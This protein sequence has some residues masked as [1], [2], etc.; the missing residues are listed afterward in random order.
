[1][2]F[3][4]KHVLS[5]VRYFWIF[6]FLL[7]PLKGLIAENI[8]YEFGPK[9]DNV[10]V[11]TASAGSDNQSTAATVQLQKYAQQLSVGAPD[12]HIIVAIT[13]ND[14][15][16]LPVDIPVKRYEGTQSLIQTLSAYPNAAVCLIAPARADNTRIVT[17]TSQGTTPAWLLRAVYTCLE[18]QNI[19]VDF[20]TNAVVFH[21]LGWL[22]DDPLLRLYN[23]AKIPAIKI[24][25]GADLSEVFSSVAPAVI[26]NM[27]NEWDTHYFVWKLHTKLIIINERHIVITLIVSSIVF[28]LWLMFFSFLFGKKRDQH[29]R[30]LLKLWWMPGYFFLVNWLSFF[31]GSKIAEA[32]FYVRFGAMGE[33]SAF[34]LTALS[35]KYVFALFFMFAVTA[36][37]KFIPLPANRFIYGFIAHA[38]CLL[39]I[40][41]FSFINLSFSIIFMVIYFVSLAAYHFK[42]IVLQIIFIV[43]LFL[44]LMPFAMHIILYRDYMFHIMFFIN[45]APACIFVPFDLFLIRLSLS[46]DKK[47]KIVKPILRIP[48]QCKVMGGLFLALTLW[49][50]VMPATRNTAHNRWMLVQHLNGDKSTVIKKYIEPPAEEVI[51]DYTRTNTQDTAENADSFL[52]VRTSFENYFERSIGVITIDSPLKI[53]AFSVTVSAL[54]DI[55]IFESDVAFEQSSSG[56]TATFVSSSR[57]NFP[58]VIHF[59]GKKDA[60]LTLSVVVWSNDNPFGISLIE[61]NTQETEAQAE[62]IPF[63]LKV[64]KTLHITAQ[65]KG[66]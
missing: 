60:A 17:G 45:L 28:L 41:I 18:Q 3:V 48:I 50:F 37:N 61:G 27:S 6:L 32:L 33:L 29:I 19:P 24:E 8:F 20:Y 9:T 47:R 11:F 53:E 16:E 22:P 42:N 49:T 21:R 12:V 23:E 25:S 35:I 65:G 57:P 4:H 10:I 5:A 36:F 39:N 51:T 15:S 14:V 13:K 52:T 58:V 62:N 55:A 26:Q 30:D 46:F 2:S 54:N 56:D 7:F 38:V 40:F 43:C 64:E 63:L 31:L 44:P 1:M 34:P 59:S 66:V